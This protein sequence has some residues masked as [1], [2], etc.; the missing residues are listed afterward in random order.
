MYEL[1][2]GQSMML[3]RDW[4]SGLIGGMCGLMTMEAIAVIVSGCGRAGMMR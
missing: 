3:S 4:V 1:A 2:V